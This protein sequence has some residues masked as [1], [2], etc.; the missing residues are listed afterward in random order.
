LE[1]IP[2]VVFSPDGKLLASASGDKTIRLWDAGSGAA[3]R[4]LNGH[5][6]YVVAAVFSPDGKLLASA[7]GDKTIRLWDARSEAAL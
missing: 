4:T 3:L 6:G 2:T 1:H 7:S 5:S